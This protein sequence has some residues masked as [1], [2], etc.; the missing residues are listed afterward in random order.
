MKYPYVCTACSKTFELDLPI[1]KAPVKTAC[2]RCSAEAKRNYAD[3][4]FA[5][6]GGS[7][8]TPS[9]GR[10]RQ[11]FG[12]EMLNRNRDA[13]KRMKANR[14]PVRRVATDYGGGDIRGV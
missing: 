5:V 6:I 12:Q 7:I 10:S 4:N 3:I 9:N 2:V 14:P 11:T 8:S 1:G 13:G